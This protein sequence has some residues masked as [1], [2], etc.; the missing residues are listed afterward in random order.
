MAAT[1]AD[2]TV[3]GWVNNLKAFDWGTVFTLSVEHRQQN[4]R[5][6]W[7]TVDRTQFDVKTTDSVPDAKQLLVTGRVTGTTTYAKKD[8]TTGVSIKLKATTLEAVEMTEAPF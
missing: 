8:G 5:G 1:R 2:I 7:E 6:E 3:T 4:D